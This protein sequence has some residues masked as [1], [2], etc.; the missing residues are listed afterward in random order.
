M[1]KLVAVVFR[2][3]A[4]A[5]QGVRAFAEMNNEGSIDVAAVCVVTKAPDGTV[6]SREVTDYKFPV[7]TLV[8]TSVGALAGV[9]AGPAGAAAG[10]AVGA[11]VGASVG[12]LAGMV[13]DLYSYGVDADFVSDVE[14]ALTPGK[15]AVIAEVEEE[16]VTPLDTR[17]EAL[18]GAVYRTLK[19][20]VREDQAKREAAA[21]REDLAQ[22]K[23]EASQARADRKAKLQARIENL[24]KRID[25]KLARAQARSQQDARD[26]EAKVKALRQKAEQQKGDA[27]A[28]VEARI[29]KLRQDYESQAHA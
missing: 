24:S 26:Y 4:T 27:K 22:L 11:G 3:E 16:W 12:A 2:D 15:S 25:A 5:Y 23:I 14:T 8:G 19:S 20:T 29:A 1:N 17:M 21:A 10:A 18:G 6:S 28:A 9:L 7:R 13:G